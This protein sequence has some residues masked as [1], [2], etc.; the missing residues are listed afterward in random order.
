MRQD[1]GRLTVPAS[2]S[3]LFEVKVS[4]A[5]SGTFD[6]SQNCVNWCGISHSRFM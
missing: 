6:I 4:A 3:W 2:E 5:H 1:V